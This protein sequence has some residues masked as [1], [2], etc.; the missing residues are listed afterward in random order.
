VSKKKAGGQAI[1]QRQK[2][3]KQKSKTWTLQWT[4]TFSP[5]PPLKATKKKIEN[6]RS[7]GPST[8][9]ARNMK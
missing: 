4:I 3:Q 6:L 7:E 5:T 1:G 2:R 9:E 8:K